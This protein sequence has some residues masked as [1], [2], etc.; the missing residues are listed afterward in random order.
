MAVLAGNAFAGMPPASATASVTVTTASGPGAAAVESYLRQIR[1]EPGRLEAFLTE[2]P[3][4]ADLHT[5]LSG[6]VPTGRLL[7]WAIDDGLCIDEHEVAA[8]PPCGPGTRPAADARTD[9]AFADRIIAAWSMKGHS[10]RSGESGHDHFFAAFAKFGAATEHKPRMLAAIA[11]QAAA[12]HTTYLE[13]LISRQ[14]EAIKKLAATVTWRDDLPAMTRQITGHPQFE[15]IVAAADAETDADLART[16]ELLKC[17]TARPDPGCAVEIRIDHQVARIGDPVRVLANLL[18]GFALAERN[19]RVVGV[20]L[21][22]PEDDPKAISEYARQMRMIAHLRRSYRTARVSLHAGELTPK[23]AGPA[24]L[25]SHIRQAVLIAGADRIGHGVDIAGE[26]DSADTLATMAAR[27][28]MVEIN[29]TSNCQILRVC[30]GEH[31]FTLYRRHRVPVALSTDDAG[32]EH[33][34]LTHEYA[35]AL[36]DF[37][38]TYADLKTLARTSLEHAFLPGAS[39]WRKAGEHR[40]VA[41]CAGQHLG[42]DRPGAACA[43]FLRDNPKAALQWRHEADLRRFE[44]RYTFS[45]APSQ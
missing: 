29:L 7:E 24:A 17:G 20:N 22:Q 19:P 31:P 15:R 10:E 42:A 25:K 27:H 33:T 39:L 36:R 40:P 26:D 28:T 11:S 16:R 32:I 14:S 2:L 18:V 38:L 30:G 34:D 3:K 44:Q 41:A 6:A 35:R 8:A 37:R 1:D 13:P 12:E 43:A 5:H 23:F 9:Q 21:V 4:G 45:P